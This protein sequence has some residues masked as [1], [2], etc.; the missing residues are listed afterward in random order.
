M[1]LLM[2]LLFMIL[3]VF[4]YVLPMGVMRPR[5]G[6]VGKMGTYTNGRV[7]K[8][9]HASSGTTP[10]AEDST[11]VK[12]STLDGTTPPS[13]HSNGIFNERVEVTKWRHYSDFKD[14]DGVNKIAELKTMYLINPIGDGN[15]G[16]YSLFAAAYG[17]LADKNNIEFHERFFDTED[18]KYGKLAG[19]LVKSG[20]SESNNAPKCVENII[21]SRFMKMKNEMKNIG[22]IRTCKLT[23][24]GADAIA[25]CIRYFIIRHAL[26]EEE[27][28]RLMYDDRY[29]SGSNRGKT[30]EYCENKVVKIYFHRDSSRNAWLHTTD[31][32][33]F[34][35]SLK[36]GIKL[37]VFTK[38]SPSNAVLTLSSLYGTETPTNF[39]L[40]Y[41]MHL[42][43]NHFAAIA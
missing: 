43:G 21:T 7:S 16:P 31:L 33:I 30:K 4:K 42:N 29:R 34:A 6:E 24:D 2:G 25:L 35:Q 15:C 11:S 5:R 8:T 14:I 40:V 37:V 9:K 32:I 12:T 18:G 17:L 13:E 20:T 27:H 19:F 28:I 26:E 22:N 38:S 3:N 1:A 36:I 39:P 10:P 41:M 23:K